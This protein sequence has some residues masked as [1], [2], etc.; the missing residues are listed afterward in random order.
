MFQV[1]TGT[2]TALPAAVLHPRTSA[3]NCRGGGGGAAE[4][5]RE[6][7]L[8]EGKIVIGLPLLHVCT[9]M[10]WRKIENVMW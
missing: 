10:F 6:G 7:V 2:A 8:Q 5:E 3:S 1:S 4:R 9:I